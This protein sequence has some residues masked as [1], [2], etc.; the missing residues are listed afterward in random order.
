MKKLS[1]F[2]Y[3]PI[4][5][6]VGISPI[7]AESNLKYFFGPSNAYN[8]VL[9]REVISADTIKLESGEK[10]KLIGLRAPAIPKSDRDDIERDEHGIPVESPVDPKKDASVEMRSYFFA[11]KLLEG[12]RVRLEFDT[13]KKNENY[14]TLA[15]I[16]L[17]KDNLFANAE[18]I[19]QGYAE[20]SQSPLNTKYADQ[21]RAAYKEARDEHRGLFDQ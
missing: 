16:F 6:T 19:R 13:E 5:T 2:L 4:L 20:L 8:N 18:I 17:P 21:L 14:E 1:L 15:Y 7:F 9:V 12:K 10:I 3:V 11:V